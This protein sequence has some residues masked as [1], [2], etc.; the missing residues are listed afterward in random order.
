V[1]VAGAISSAS[2]SCSSCCPV[3]NF[4]IS[5]DTAEDWLA[6]HPEVSGQVISVAEAAAAGRAVF[7]DVLA[8]T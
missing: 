8:L 4:F 5:P 2:K 7:G 6:R 1:V 3:L